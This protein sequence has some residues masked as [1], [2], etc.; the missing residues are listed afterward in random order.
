M[1][2]S[3][4]SPDGR[5]V[6]PDDLTAAVNIFREAGNDRPADR[7][8][9]LRDNMEDGDMPIDGKSAVIM[10]SFMTA[11]DKYLPP[12]PLMTVS[13][14]GYIHIE[15]HH[16][17]KSLTLMVFHPDGRAKFVTAADDPL[18]NSH[19]IAPADGCLAYLRWFWDTRA[20]AGNGE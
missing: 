2:V 8:E 11:N 5:C 6:M 10:A 20:E 16:E 7:L 17:D 14:D 13:P 4:S 1:Y 9:F 15:W 19:G 12:N 18:G 3:Y